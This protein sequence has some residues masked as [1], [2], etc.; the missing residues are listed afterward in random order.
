MS[1]FHSYP[2]GG[3]ARAD[4][5]TGKSDPDRHGP[6]PLVM[7]ANTLEGN[8]VVSPNGEDLGTVNHIMLDVPSGRVAYAV[9]PFGA[10]SALARSCSRSPGL[11]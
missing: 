7:A 3:R 11:R 6:G 10:I 2:D 5:I 1:Q 9:L 8:N 4:G